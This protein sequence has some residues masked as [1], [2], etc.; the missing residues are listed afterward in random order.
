MIVHWGCKPKL[1]VLDSV[2]RG[3]TCISG[4]LSTVSSYSETLIMLCKSPS[5]PGGLFTCNHLHC[6]SVHWL[7]TGNLNMYVEVAI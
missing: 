4:T 5:I 1:L 3:C 7:L 2:L 6:G